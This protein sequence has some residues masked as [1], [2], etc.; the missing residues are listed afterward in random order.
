[1]GGGHTFGITKRYP[2]LFN[3]IGLFSAAISLNAK[4]FD[5]IQDKDQRIAPEVEQQLRVLFQKKPALYWIAIGQ[6]DF[7]YNNNKVY[8]EYLDAKG[9][10]YEYEETD[11][12]HIWRNWRI[13]LTQ[14][15][16]R[17]FR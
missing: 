4:G 9:Y 5:G 8:R 10:P 15:S 7:L 11:G 6:T 13:Y 2:D 17:L 14:F 12:G 16:Q 1:M 3:Y